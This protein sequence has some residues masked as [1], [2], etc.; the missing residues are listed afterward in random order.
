MIEINCY[1]LGSVGWMKE[2]NCYGLWSAD[3]MIE[4]NCYGL[5]SVSHMI[6]I[7][8]YGQISVACMI[9]INCN[10]LGSVGCMI[11]F[12]GHSRDIKPAR[13]RILPQGSFAP[14]ILINIQQIR[15]NVYSSYHQ[16][17]YRQ[18]RCAVLTRLVL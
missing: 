15:Q 12:L 17:R 9:E 3:C 14:G 10:G 8:Y 18:L 16:D 5:W 7:K 13:I 1:D 2:I 11:F 4:I 6:E